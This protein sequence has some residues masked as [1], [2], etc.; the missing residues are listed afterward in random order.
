ML[1]RETKVEA[2][3]QKHSLIKKQHLIDRLLLFKNM[4]LQFFQDFQLQKGCI[5]D[6]TLEKLNNTA[7]SFQNKREFLNSRESKPPRQSQVQ[8]YSNVSSK[9]KKNKDKDNFNINNIS[10]ENKDKA[11]RSASKSIV[12]DGSYISHHSKR[13]SK[14]PSAINSNN[15]SIIET[16]DIKLPV[17][18]SSHKHSQD[19][20]N[21]ESALHSD[22]NNI[23]EKKQSVNKFKY[24][25]TKMNAN[26][27]KNSSPDLN[28][29]LNLNLKSKHINLS[30]NSKPSNS[31]DISSRNHNNLSNMPSDNLKSQSKNAQG[32]SHNLS[33]NQNTNDTKYI[34]NIGSMGSIGSL[35]S[36]KT[37]LPQFDENSYKLVKIKTR[38]SSIEDKFN[39]TKDLTFADSKGGDSSYINININ[40]EREN[41]NNNTNIQY[42]ENNLDV[43]RNYI[44][45]LAMD[46]FDRQYNTEY[47][48]ASIFGGG[49]LTN[50]KDASNFIKYTDCD[51]NSTG[52]FK[53]RYDFFMNDETILI[54]KNLPQ[55]SYG[56]SKIIPR[57]E[58]HR[59]GKSY[60]SLIKKNKMKILQ[61]KLY[62]TKKKLNL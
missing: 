61:D 2:D 60:F 12:Y 44:D 10:K 39:R 24:L 40:G 54:N 45:Y 46:N 48:F 34:S 55:I 41:T 27:N 59:Y 43:K 56:Q 11:E 49:K 35:S 51:M 6:S 18:A 37:F 14:L 4:R 23:I 62:N 52:Q 22:L 53:K 7:S 13:T 21:L 1:Q 33:Q 8:L 5:T 32:H 47:Y 57:K 50:N 15:N 30:E 38:N 9:M 42:D 19:T 28:V 29:N 25:N 17:Q 3:T 36:M 16:K 58:E 26:L 31:I 20:P